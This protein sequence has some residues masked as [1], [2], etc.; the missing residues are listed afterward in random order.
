MVETPPEQNLRDL[1]LADDPEFSEVMRC[2]FDIQNHETRTYLTL[3]AN[4]S[5]TVAELATQLE[6]DRSSVNRSLT[7]LLDKGLVEREHRLLDT[8]GYVYQYQAASIAE[9]QQQMHDALE[10][11]T[12]FMHAKIDEF[13]IDED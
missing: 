5:S 11:W 13:G 12:E 9:A 10:E 3:R 6:K 2:V 8:G 1:M 4:P 7:K